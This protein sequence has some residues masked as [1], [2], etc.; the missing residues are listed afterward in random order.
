M[1]HQ[2]PTRASELRQEYISQSISNRDAPNVRHFST[3]KAEDYSYVYD[4]D[5]TSF[6]DNLSDKLDFLD[7]MKNAQAAQDRVVKWLK[8]VA[9]YARANNA[10]Q[11]LNAAEEELS[12]FTGSYSEKTYVHDGSF[13]SA[14]YDEGPQE[15]YTSDDIDSKFRKIK[16]SNSGKVSPSLEDALRA[17]G[18]TIVTP[19]STVATTNQASERPKITKSRAPPKKVVNEKEYSTDDTM[20]DGSDE[21][22]TE[23]YNI[24]KLQSENEALTSQL[25]RLQMEYVKVMGGEIVHTDDGIAIILG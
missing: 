1:S 7:R 18:S 20:S 9:S 8:N 21:G 3:R 11:I 2:R 5:I 4:D 25:T 15:V 6:E 13:I 16:P 17:I 23:E 10:P 19:A 24:F 12:Q 14:R 22:T